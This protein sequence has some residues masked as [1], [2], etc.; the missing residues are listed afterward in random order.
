MHDSEPFWVA[1]EELLL[2]GPHWAFE[3]ISDIAATAVVWTVGS[4]IPDR[5]NPV[6]RWVKRHDKEAHHG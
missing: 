6:K 3:F 4:I 2:S 5:F 1:L